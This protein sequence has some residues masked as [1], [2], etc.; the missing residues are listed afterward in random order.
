[1]DD[2]LGDRGFPVA[3]RR[4]ILEDGRK[5]KRYEWRF[6][7]RE[8][9]H[10]AANLVRAWVTGED[11]ETLLARDPVLARAAARARSSCQV[12]LFEVAP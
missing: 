10:R 9:Y 2:T 12:S 5:L 1:M 7:T 8:V 11:F 6:E 4:I 3:R